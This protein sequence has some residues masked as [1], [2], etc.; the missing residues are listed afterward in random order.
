MTDRRMF[1]EPSARLQ[2]Y[3]GRELIS[4]PNLAVIEFVKNSYDAGAA[5]VVVDFRLRE[6]PTSLLISDD[7]VGMDEEAFRSNWLRP[8]FSEKSMDYHGPA[9]FARGNES[10]V[11]RLSRREPAGEKGLGRLAAGRLGG[12][13]EVWT[14][15]TPTDSWMHV[16]FD[17][18]R[19]DDMTK[20]ITDVDIPYDFTTAPPVEEF[21]S[22]TVVQVSN[23]RQPWTGRVPGRAV[24]GR[25]RTRL[26]RLKQDLQFLVR[27][28]EP[29]Y[30]RFEVDLRSDA[31]TDPDDVG[32]IVAG[33]GQSTADYIYRFSLDVDEADY[34]VIKRSIKRSVAIADELD[35]PREQELPE[36]TVNHTAAKREGRPEELRC[37]PF[38]GTFIYTPPPAARRASKVDGFASGVLLYRDGV[39]VEPYGLPGD[40]WVGV[41]ARKASRQGHA[42]IQPATFSGHVMISRRENRELEDMSNRLGLLENEASDDFF[43][44]V[45]AEFAFFEAI[46]YEEIL[47]P[48]WRT[49]AA[50]ATVQARHAAELAAVRLRATAHSAGQPLQALAFDVIRLEDIASRSDLPQ[51]V[52]DDLAHINR[53]I[54]THLDKLGSIIARF[55]G[56]SVPEFRDTAVQALIDA[57]YREKAP[58]AEAEG[59]A[60]CVKPRVSVEDLSVLV[61]AELIVDAVEELL[62]NAIEAPRPEGVSAE[63]ELVIS[64]EEPNVVRISIIDNGTGI[65]GKGDDSSILGVPSTKARPA[66]GLPLVENAVKVSQGSVRILQ[67]GPSGTTIAIDL[68]RMRRHS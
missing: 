31:F 5:N 9:L 15:P 2:R 21:G 55:T 20:R 60:L 48:R 23:L 34:V 43:E 52:K 61:P 3:L 51:D 19:Y 66:E 27:P 53:R 26:G 10:A 47:R 38:S 12:R 45:R 32:I 16:V 40:D 8:G 36:V 11:K 41:E 42:A 50:K 63:V 39:L 46:I 25:A 37:G 22:G 33:E 54:G 67:T 62:A 7:G 57:A 14:R 44:H 64:A 65:E 28:L 35:L 68:P 58:L 56:E 13:M 24:R 30:R 1:F 6:K 49:P 29:E 59:V 18:A 17:W 4:D